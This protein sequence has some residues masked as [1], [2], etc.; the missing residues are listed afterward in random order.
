[1]KTTPLSFLGMNNRANDTGLPMPDKLNPFGKFRNAVNVDFDN[2][3]AICFPRIGSTLACA[4]TACHSW[5]EFDHDLGFGF[6]VDGI[7]LKRLNRD[8]TATVLQTVSAGPMSFC[9]VSDAIY[10]SN[11]VDTGIYVNGTIKP[12]GIQTPQTQPYASATNLGGMYGGD[13]RVAITW[14]TE[15]S[16]DHY[17]ESGTFESTQVTVAD[18]GGI[19][20][21]AF[22][23]P[24]SYVDLV[25]VY[26]SG[27][28]GG[29]DN[30]DSTGEGLYLYDE[31][32][33]NVSDVTIRYNVGTVNL[34]TQF[35]Y[36][37][38]PKLGLTLHYGRIYWPDGNY[39]YFTEAQHYGL[40]RVNSYY[41]FE[42]AVTNVVS[43]PGALYVT[44]GKAIYKLFGID[45]ETPAGNVKVKTYGAPEGSVYYDDNDNFALVVT[46]NGFAIFTAEGVKELSAEHIAFP[47]FEKGS[48]AIVEHL[49][50]RRAI[51]VMQGGTVSRLQHAD[52]TASD[53]ARGGTGL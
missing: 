43:T 1:M 38:Q 10:F 49:G 53:I 26:V 11:G 27:V 36:K 48:V 30:P 50:T 18:G 41:R 8:D 35:G 6:F 32:P 42:E 20:L 25:A 21:T 15:I 16:P 39:V 24:P 52:Y 29:S 23:T 3:G 51:A 44:T 47:T 28:N 22:P 2:S 40:Q 37:P 9:R 4:G 31:Y 17:Q 7:S 34:D 45:G 46:D 19:H 33:A 13:Y 5:Y 12:W 14:L